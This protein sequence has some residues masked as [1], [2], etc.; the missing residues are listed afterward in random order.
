VFYVLLSKGLFNAHR[1]RTNSAGHHRG[2]GTFKAC[3]S[4]VCVVYDHPMFLIWY[5]PIT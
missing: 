4:C 3:V 1:N 5:M 2:L